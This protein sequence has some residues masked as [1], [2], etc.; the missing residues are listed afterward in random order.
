MFLFNQ[1]NADSMPN[2]FAQNCIFSE[3]RLFFFSYWKFLIFANVPNTIMVH[4]KTST[5]ITLPFF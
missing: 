3:I 1:I 5:V 4:A 2:A